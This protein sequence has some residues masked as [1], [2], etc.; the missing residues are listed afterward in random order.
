MKMLH[1]RTGT[2]KKRFR[3]FLAYPLHPRLNPFQCL[4]IIGH[5]HRKQR[6]MRSTSHVLFGDTVPMPFTLPW[7]KRTAWKTPSERVSFCTVMGSRLA[8]KVAADSTRRW[9]CA[10]RMSWPFLYP[11]FTASLVTSMP[12]SPVYL[13]VM[14]SVAMA[15]MGLAPAAGGGYFMFSMC[16]PFTSSKTMA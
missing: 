16:A 3:I 2:L 9:S 14:F 4:P 5:M 8:P 13:A 10:V 6:M 7:F 12:L 11:S 1:V 15:L